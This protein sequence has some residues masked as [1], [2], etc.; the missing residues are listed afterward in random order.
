[1]WSDIWNV[2]YIELRI[3][4]QV[5][6]DHRSYERPSCECRATQKLRNS[7]VVYHKTKNSFGAKICMNGSFKLLL[8]QFQTSSNNFQQV[9][10]TR[11]NKQHGV[12]SLATCWAQQCCVLLANNVASVC[13]GLNDPFF[14][15]K[16]IVNLPLPLPVLT[17]LSMSHC[18]RV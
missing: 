11:N 3:W 17:E 15:K 10:T 12:Q 13:M 16:N 18:S 5:S 4:N 1:M 9:A 6:Y 7:S 8:D 2:S 14:M